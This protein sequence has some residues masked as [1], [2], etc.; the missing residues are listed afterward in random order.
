[1]VVTVRYASV[2]QTALHLDGLA[3]QATV[4]HRR[5]ATLHRLAVVQHLLLVVAEEFQIRKVRALQQHL[6]VDGLLAL[7]GDGLV[8]LEPGGDRDDL[9]LLGQAHAAAVQ[10]VVGDVE[11]L[12]VLQ[13]G[14]LLQADVDLVDVLVDAEVLH[15]GV[16]LID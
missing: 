12:H 8:R 1:M 2:V 16:V 11:Q 7:A 4:A 5:H 15:A 13:T 3:Q 14:V 9:A 6:R 10:V